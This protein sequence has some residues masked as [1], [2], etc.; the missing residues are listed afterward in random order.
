MTPQDH[1]PESRPAI[2]SS[3]INK[4]KPITDGSEVLH[5]LI[6]DCLKTK[7]PHALALGYLQYETVRKMHV[8]TFKDL[9]MRNLEGE[10]FDSLVVEAL[11]KNTAV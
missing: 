2:F 6:E 9:F 4:S 3:S 8:T 1:P 7:S 11:I 5:S 10:D